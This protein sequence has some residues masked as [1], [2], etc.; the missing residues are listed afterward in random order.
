MRHEIRVLEGE[1]GRIL[2]AF[3]YNSVLAEKVKT[4]KKRRFQGILPRARMSEMQNVGV[5]QPIKEE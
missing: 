5:N 3:S 1:S 2:A 4:T